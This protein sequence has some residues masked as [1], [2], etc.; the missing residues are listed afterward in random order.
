MSHR[1]KSTTTISETMVEKQEKRHNL[2]E[3]TDTR[4]TYPNNERHNHE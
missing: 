1:S 3:M 4:S 2:K